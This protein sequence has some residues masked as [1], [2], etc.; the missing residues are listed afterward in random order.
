MVN[1]DCIVGLNQKVFQHVTLKCP[2]YATVGRL[3]QLPDTK[4]YE[5][6]FQISFKPNLITM[7]I[8]RMKRSSNFRLPIIFLSLSA[9]L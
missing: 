7:L 4:R 2:I 8:I 3:W 5:L 6:V 9:L 1:V